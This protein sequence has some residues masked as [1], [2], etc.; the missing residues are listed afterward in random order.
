MCCTYRFQVS[1]ASKVTPR[2]FTRVGQSYSAFPSR[3]VR[4]PVLLGFFL[5]LTPFHQPSTTTRAFSISSEVMP[6]YF[7]AM[8][9]IR[10]LAYPGHNSLCRLVLSASRQ[11]PNLSLW[12]SLGNGQLNCL[13]KQ[14]VL[15]YPVSQHA[16]QSYA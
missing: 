13:T 8:S 7:T 15:C 9:T 6:G 16:V 10:E 1:I 2:Y 4:R 3:E 14:L 12:V 5:R 11:L